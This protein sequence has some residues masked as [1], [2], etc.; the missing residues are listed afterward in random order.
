MKPSYRIIVKPQG[1]AESQDVTERFR[2]RLLSMRIV[3]RDGLTSDSLEIAL[4]DRDHQLAIPKTGDKLEVYIGYKETGLYKMGN[5]SVDEVTLS[6]PPKT[7][8]IRA[9]AADMTVSLKSCKYREWKETTLG[10]VVAKI[11]KEHQLTPKIGNTLK[12]IPI[13]HLDQT[14]ESNLNLLARLAKQ[15]NATCKP[16]DG[17]LV[18]VERGTELTISGK[19]PEKVDIDIQQ[20]RDWRWTL[21]E[22]CSYQHVVAHYRDKEKSMDQYVHAG[23]GEPTACLPN[24]FPDRQSAEK[25][26]KAALERSLQGVQS[27]SITMPGAPTVVAEA[28]LNLLGFHPKIDGDWR[29][30]QVTHDMNNGGYTTRVEASLPKAKVEISDAP[31]DDF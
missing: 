18:F 30:K 24:T 4:D 5:F 2:K 26:A 27:M 12:D 10:E 20:I 14:Y 9:K 29:A 17:Q 22:R 28:Q 7:M 21:A 31:T 6:G 13:P 15:Y 19:K 25:A 1:G 3:D 8:S 11:A 23:K 16:V